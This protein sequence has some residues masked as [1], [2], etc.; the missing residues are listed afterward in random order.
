ML[1]DKELSLFDNLL[2]SS[3]RFSCVMF[4][5]GRFYQMKSTEQRTHKEEIVII[6]IVFTIFI[7]PITNEKEMEE[8]ISRTIWTTTK[9]KKNNWKND[10]FSSVSPVN[11]RAVDF[12]SLLHKHRSKHCTHRRLRL[13]LEKRQVQSKKVESILNTYNWYLFQMPLNKYD[14]RFELV[15]VFDR[16][17]RRK[18]FHDYKMDIRR[19]SEETGFVWCLFEAFV[20]FS[21]DPF[22]LKGREIN[23]D[24]SFEF[25]F[26]FIELLIV[27]QK[28]KK[29][30]YWQNDQHQFLAMYK[31]TR[32]FALHMHRSMHCR[33]RGVR[34]NLAQN[35]S[36][37]NNGCDDSNDPLQWI[38]VE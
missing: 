33:H 11:W 20:Y 30:R 18:N 21:Y 3:I 36:G 9:E 22:D 38:D 28:H 24:S 19:S 14:K 17:W 13:N 34:S 23:R 35:R 32:D 12:C 15:V 4:C 8:N 2:R 31:I 26:Y 6:V 37:A 29:D 16:I 1:F 5:H 25:D 7:S 10:L 27:R